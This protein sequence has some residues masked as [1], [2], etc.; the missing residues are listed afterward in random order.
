MHARQ[1]AGDVVAFNAALCALD[2]GSQ[3][4]EAIPEFV[5]EKR[6][7]EL[8]LCSRCSGIDDVGRH[9][10]G[11]AQDNPSQVP[12]S[13]APS[14]VVASWLVLH[15]MRLKRS[16]ASYGAVISACGDAFQWEVTWYNSGGS[17]QDAAWHSMGSVLCELLRHFETK[18]SIEL[19][20][21]LQ[22]QLLEALEIYRMAVVIVLSTICPN[23]ILFSGDFWR[24]QPNLIVMNL[25]LNASR[26]AMNVQECQTYGM[27]LAESCRHLPSLASCASLCRDRRTICMCP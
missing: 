21:L 24:L 25:C 11:W 16:L 10:P 22:K 5:R 2:R 6:G 18:E 14:G 3:W 20:S 8:V 19:L 26:K 1:I 9:E 7:S 27:H 4:Q 12:K 13:R 23:Q 17:T 15:Q